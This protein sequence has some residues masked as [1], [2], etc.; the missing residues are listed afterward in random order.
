MRLLNADEL[1][2]F[3]NIHKGRKIDS[4]DIARFPAVDAEP[5]KHGRW[6]RDKNNMVVCS[7]CNVEPL[8]DD[9]GFWH[10]S[11]YCPNCGCK[12]DLEEAR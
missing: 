9:C 4:N 5:V 10:K 3:A 7:T 11:I 1:I 8:L 6:I 12:M 2:K